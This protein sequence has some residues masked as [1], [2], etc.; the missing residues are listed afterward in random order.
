MKNQPA[1]C[2]CMKPQSLWSAIL[3]LSTFGI[4]CVLLE[5]FKDTLTSGCKGRLGEGTGMY[6]LG[7]L[8]VY[9]GVSECYFIIL[10]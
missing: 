9:F 8:Y 5:I 7:P 10:Y 4:N 1:T 2:H 3:L 6:A